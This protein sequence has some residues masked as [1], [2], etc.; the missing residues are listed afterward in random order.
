MQYHAIPASS[1][2]WANQTVN[3]ILGLGGEAFKWVFDMYDKYYMPSL[4]SLVE[5]AMKKAH[6]P[7]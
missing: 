7:V 3:A 2:P 1:V 4:I 6:C 5:K